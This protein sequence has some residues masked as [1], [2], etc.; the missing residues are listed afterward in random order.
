MK[1][2][3]L[4]VVLFLSMPVFAGST[5]A[6]LWSIF[7]RRTVEQ[8]VALFNELEKKKGYVINGKLYMGSGEVYMDNLNTIRIDGAVIR[9]TY[10][11]LDGKF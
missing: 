11:T 7:M 4:L 2:V 6:G 1:I 9:D 8:D 3:S 10:G 5:D